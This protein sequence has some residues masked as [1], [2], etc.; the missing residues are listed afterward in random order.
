MRLVWLHITNCWWQSSK[1][2]VATLSHRLQRILWCIHQCR[3]LYKPG[4]QL[5][6]ADW[7]CRHSH[8]E[9]WVE[10]IP[11]MKCEHACHRNMYRH[12]GIH[13]GRGNLACN[14]KRWPNICIIDLCDIQMA[15]NRSWGHIRS[16][17]MLVLQKWSGGHLW[18]CRLIDFLNNRIKF[19]DCRQAFA[20]FKHGFFQVWG[21]C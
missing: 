5:F 13:D 9:N 6:I 11:G 16:T 8:N 15:I 21:K 17:T 10:E 19:L 20:S 14:P 3:I 4:L 18:D 7:L 2:D 1:K 12:P